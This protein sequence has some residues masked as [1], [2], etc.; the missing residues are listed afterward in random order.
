MKGKKLLALI[1]CIAIGFTPVISPST[2]AHASSY[3]APEGWRNLQDFYV[4]KDKFNGWSGS[5][6]E[7]ETVNGDLPVDTQETYENLPSL[8]FNITTKLHDWM[9]VILVMA[10]W[11]S[12]DI[13][14]YVPNGYLEFNVKGKNGGEQFIIG[15]R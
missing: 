6:G 9:S 14:N 4:F 11:A 7:L 2:V 8:R 12:H 3:G 10:G 1:A 15:G 5:S 13:H